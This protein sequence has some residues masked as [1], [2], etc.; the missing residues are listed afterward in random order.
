M[1]RIGILTFYYKNYNYGGILQAYALEHFLNSC[2]HDVKAE[3]ICYDRT[4][5]PL[6]LF[7]RTIRFLCRGDIKRKIAKQP[8]KRALSHSNYSAI[9][10]FASDTIIHT[11]RVYDGI[12]YRDMGA[13]Y[14]VLICGS[15]QVWNPIAVRDAY[16]FKKINKKKISYAASIAAGDLKLP[17][18]IKYKKALSSFSAISVREESARK[19]LVELIDKK[20]ATVLDPVLLLTKDDWN[21]VAADRIISKPY[22]FTY[23][24]GNVGANAKN[25]AERSTEKKIV[26]IEGLAFGSENEEILSG[27]GPDEFLSLIKYADEIWTDSFHALVFSVIFERPFRVFSREGEVADMS[28]RITDILKMLELKPENQESYRNAKKILEE[29]REESIVFLKNA[30]Y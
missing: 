19:Q 13:E 4:R 16:F 1:I 14:D 9:D 24:L 30:I 22:M 12:S 21:A 6:S 18:R 11:E 8:A 27:V 26:S 7:D 28:E 5:V 29:K 17:E 15:D 23:F 25:G 2:F 10:K 20:I 3:Q